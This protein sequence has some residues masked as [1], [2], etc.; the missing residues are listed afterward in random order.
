MTP[1]D[2]IVASWD[3]AWDISDTRASY[4][5]CYIAYIQTDAVG[6]CDRSVRSRGGAASVA[7]RSGD[8]RLASGGAGD[9]MDLLDV[10]TSRQLVRNAAGG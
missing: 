2:S 10:G 6:G 3:T 1:P 4:I 8:L 9:P 7:A 5:A